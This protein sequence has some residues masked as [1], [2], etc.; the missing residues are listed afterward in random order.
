M[1][2]DLS[3][4]LNEVKLNEILKAVLKKRRFNDIGEIKNTIKNYMKINLVD[5]M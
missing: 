5:I 4:D 3:Y 1:K 2:N